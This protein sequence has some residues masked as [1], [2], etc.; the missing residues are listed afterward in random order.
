MTSEGE[1]LLDWMNTFPEVQPLN[2]ANFADLR[3]GK[4]IALLWNTVQ[5]RKSVV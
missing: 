2:I 1:A 3:D 5:D 4:G